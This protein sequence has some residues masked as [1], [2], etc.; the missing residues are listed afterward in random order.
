M[1][2]SRKNKTLYVDKEAK[3]ALELVKDGLFYPLMH[4]M[5][6]KKSKKVLETG[7]IDGKSFPFPFI[8]APNGAKNEVVLKSLEIGEEITIFCDKKAFATSE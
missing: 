7:L 4:L 3:S 1:V 8:L 2:L 6:E 5:G